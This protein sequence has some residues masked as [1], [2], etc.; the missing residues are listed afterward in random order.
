EHDDGIE[1][2]FI[3]QFEGSAKF[4]DEDKIVS[5]DDV[6]IKTGNLMGFIGFSGKGCHGTKLEIRSRF[7]ENCE[8]KFAENAEN[9]KTENYNQ[10]FFLHYMLE[11]VFKI[12]LF[13]LNY[14]YNSSGF[15]LVYLIFPYFLKRA[16]NQ[17]LF[18]T[19]KTF[20]R[21][22]SA[23]KGAINVSRHIR[24]NVP[25]GGRIAYRSRE[26][27]FDNHIMQLIRHTIEYIKTKPS[28]KS[29][30]TQDPDTQKAVSQINEVTNETYSLQKRS[31]VIFENLKPLNHSYYLDYN[32]L[33]QLC[34]MILNNAN[35]Q[36]SASSSPIYG[37]LFDGAWLWEEY[38]W[39][40]LKDA[41][42]EGK[43]FVHP[44]NRT[45][46]G[47]IHLFKKGRGLRYPDFYRKSD[48][49]VLDAKYKALSYNSKNEDDIFSEIK[50]SFKRD[51]I[52]QL[53]TY[54]YILKAEKGGFIFPD[55]YRNEYSDDTIRTLPNWL[56]LEGYGK[57]INGFG[58]V[59]PS[60]KD[61]N[62]F[63]DKM[64]NLEKNLLNKIDNT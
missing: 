51:D 30:L 32:Y 26:Y 29:I 5:C 50:I 49:I 18:K 47:G 43:N 15:D 59:I 4:N 42:L 54:M 46:K 48:N 14:S 58:L 44:N 34:L 56:E 53:V 23:V 24:Q 21:N 38:L 57:K 28:G 64:Y 60:V 16:L 22:D 31:K 6:K 19:Y 17:G 12:N 11:K 61:Y 13:N 40:I 55:K 62:L 7:S 20:E 2:Q 25:F 9:N 27:T 10:D 8:A 39:I 33:Q 3:V 41:T 45:G 1:E 35:S 63:K 37:I 36:Y 52:H